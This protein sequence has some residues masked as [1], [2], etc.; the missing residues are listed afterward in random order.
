M[1]SNSL[2]TAKF[3]G[4]FQLPNINAKPALLIRPDGRIEIGEGCTNADAVRALVDLANHHI[5]RYQVGE[6]VAYRNGDEFVCAAEYA[7]MR[8][9][10]HDGSGWRPLYAAPPVQQPAQAAQAVDDE[11]I[12]EAAERLEAAR[13]TWVNNPRNGGVMPDHQ[14]TLQVIAAALAEGR[15]HASELEAAIWRAG[16]HICEQSSE[17][18]P[19]PLLLV[20]GGTIMPVSPPLRAALAPTAWIGTPVGGGEPCVTLSLETRD[21]WVRMGREVD[22]LHRV[23]PRAS[24]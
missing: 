1:S 3:K 20:W 8:D 13:A 9:L 14:I 21:H 18:G 24:A 19:Y 2:A 4:S 23:A 12:A 6:P 7:T 16:I 10:G 5:A 11:T 22:P 17:R 15:A